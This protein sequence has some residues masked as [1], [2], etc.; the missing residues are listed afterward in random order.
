MSNFTKKAINHLTGQTIQTISEGR[1][2]NELKEISERLKL[3]LNLT[4]EQ[5]DD[6]YNTFHIFPLDLNN[7]LTIKSIQM[8]YYNSD[9][10]LSYEDSLKALQIF[11]G[12]RNN[13]HI[14][15]FE[16][17]VVNMEKWMKKVI[18]LFLFLL[19]LLLFLLSLLYFLLSFLFSLI[20]ILY[21]S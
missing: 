21:L 17:F 13:D 3:N 19:L 18:F 5:I 6:Y 4:S 10:E 2:G 8:F 14:I 16:T 9:I 11:T 15:D 7:C 20:L 12:S 1:E